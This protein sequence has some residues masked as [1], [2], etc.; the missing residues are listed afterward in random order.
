MDAGYKPML[1][2]TDINYRVSDDR[3]V[4]RLKTVRS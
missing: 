1:S 3:R 2:L 4:E